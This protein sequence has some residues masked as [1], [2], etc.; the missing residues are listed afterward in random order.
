MREL[1]GGAE[2]EEKEEEVEAPHK[3]IRT[4]CPVG[5]PAYNN[6]NVL[7]ISSRLSDWVK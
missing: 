2:E 5:P 4:I 1:E 7:C 3:R 6:I